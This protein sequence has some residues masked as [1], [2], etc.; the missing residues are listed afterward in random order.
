MAASLASAPL[1]QKKLWPPNDRSAR[2]SASAPWAS[3]YQVFGTWI[4]CPTWSRTA[5]TTRGGQ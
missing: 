1:L 4:N 5:S 2:A 3:M